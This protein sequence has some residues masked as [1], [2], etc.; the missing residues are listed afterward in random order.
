M[1]CVTSSSES[2]LGDPEAESLS[3]N[4]GLDRCSRPL[5]AV[6]PA[7]PSVSYRKTAR[8]PTTDAEQVGEASGRERLRRPP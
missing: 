1:V 8:A 6:A 5:E 3:P 2:G 7:L 4:L